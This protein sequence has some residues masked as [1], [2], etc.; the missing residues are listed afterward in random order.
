MI[1]IIAVWVYSWGAMK[2]DKVMADERL[3]ICGMG[4][5]VV[6]E[7]EAYVRGSW[8]LLSVSWRSCTISSWQHWLCGCSVLIIALR[9][10]HIESMPSNLEADISCR[11]INVESGQ[12]FSPQIISWEVV[13]NSN[14]IL[15]ICWCSSHSSVNADVLQKKP[16]CL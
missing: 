10:N 7:F 16:C 8:S 5:S 13:C 2:F 6:L 11:S 12:W 9:I 3:L 14:N 15:G 1:S 4:S